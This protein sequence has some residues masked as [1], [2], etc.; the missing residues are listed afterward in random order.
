MGR[1][2][3]RVGGAQTGW[4]SRKTFFYVFCLSTPLYRR[5]RLSHVCQTIDLEE[6]Y[7]FVSKILNFTPCGLVF[8]RFCV[9]YGSMKIH[10]LHGFPWISWESMESMELNS[11]GS[12]EF[13]RFHGIP[14]SQWISMESMEFHGVN[15]FSWSPWI[16]VK[17]TFLRQSV[18]KIVSEA[19][20]IDFR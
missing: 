3:R 18:V 12:M 11:M 4:K 5:F 13:H 15:G 2:Y 9:L 20:F 14:W 10:C 19:D 6:I 8:G 1:G 16:F 17:S 7:R